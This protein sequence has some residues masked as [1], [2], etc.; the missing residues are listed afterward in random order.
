MV[1]FSILHDTLGFRPED[2]HHEVWL[3]V[4]LFDRRGDYVSGERHNGFSLRND[5]L[6]TNPTR[7]EAEQLKTNAT[8][9]FRHDRPYER[10]GSH[11]HN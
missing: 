2:L 8:V 5:L 10:H 7:T 11:K 4:A 3:R 9:R 6:R 1:H